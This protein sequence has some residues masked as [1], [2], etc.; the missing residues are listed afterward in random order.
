MKLLTNQRKSIY[1][2][3]Y[4]YKWL[5]ALA[6]AMLLTSTIALSQS[7][8]FSYPENVANNVE[9]IPTIKLLTDSKILESSITDYY[10][11]PDSTEYDFGDPQSI[12]LLPKFVVDSIPDTL[13]KYLSVRGS[14]SL[15]DSNLL[16]F[17]P[18]GELHA[19]LEYVAKVVNLKIV[20]SFNDTF[21]VAEESIT[22]TT[23]PPAHK[24]LSKT[25]FNNGV[26][27][28][29]DTLSV[30]YNRL[31]NSTTTTAGDLLKLYKIDSVKV[32]NDTLTKFTTQLALNSWIDQQD[33]TILRGLP[34]FPFTP[35]AQYLVKVNTNYLTGDMLDYEENDISIK[36]Y[37]MLIMDV[38][39]DDTTLSVPYMSVYPDTGFTYIRYGDSLRIF[40]DREVD[41]LIFLRWECPND[42]E[43]DSLQKNS[44]TISS[45]C[46]N[47][48][49]YYVKAI[50]GEKKDVVLNIS[51]EENLAVSVYSN[52]FGYLGSSG[53]YTIEPDDFVYVVSDTGS[54]SYVFSHWESSEQYINQEE[55]EWN[56][57]AQKGERLQVTSNM[58]ANR[59][60]QVHNF[61]RNIDLSGFDAPE[62]EVKQ[63]GFNFLSYID[64]D[65]ANINIW[66]LE[67]LAFNCGYLEIYIDDIKQ[68]TTEYTTGAQPVNKSIKFVISE[69]A[70]K[71]FTALGFFVDKVVDCSATYTVPPNSTTFS[72]L[73]TSTSSFNTVMVSIKP[74]N[75][76][77][78]DL[79]V[80]ADWEDGPEHEGTG[81]IG[82]DVT[83]IADIL[84]GDEIIDARRIESDGNSM[85]ISDIYCDAQVRLKPLPLYRG[86]HFENWKD[87]DPLNYDYPTPS[88]SDPWEIT[89]DEEKKVKALFSEG[90]RVTHIG[91]YIDDNVESSTH[92]TTITWYDYNL[93]EKSNFLI[94]N[95]EVWD[96]ETNT[97]IG[98]GCK[99][100][101]KFNQQIYKPDFYNE[102]SR[103]IAYDISARVDDHDKE[104]SQRQ[105]YE[106]AQSNSN[107]ENVD[108]PDGNV[109]SLTLENFE[110]PKGQQFRLE[111]K[112]FTNSLSQDEIE[113]EGILEIFETEIP[114]VNIV[115]N[116]FHLGNANCEGFFSFIDEWGEIFIPISTSVLSLNYQ[117]NLY[118]YRSKSNT[119]QWPSTS[120]SYQ[121]KEETTAGSFS[122]FEVFESNQMFRDDFIN[123][124]NESLDEDWRDVPDLRSDA[125]NS[126]EHADNLIINNL[127]EKID[128]ILG[129]ILLNSEPVGDQRWKEVWEIGGAGFAI[130]GIFYAI[131]D[132]TGICEIIA[133][134]I[135]FVTLIICEIFILGMADKI[136]WGITL[137]NWLNHRFGSIKWNNNQHNN[138]GKPGFKTKLKKI[139]QTNSSE[140]Y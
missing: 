11:C 44:F 3:I 70:P 74:T 121:I 84:I 21:Y 2:H 25:F 35:G 78:Y 69:D 82:K 95:I 107:I 52:T 8:T 38:E 112:K 88:S 125:N 103:I 13:W 134:V 9:L 1:I 113:N 138:L 126:R 123:I 137:V 104:Q 37:A 4:I 96:Y 105:T 136:D 133:T 47:L 15:L 76:T 19:G 55:P 128:F 65:D 79:T 63:Y 18:N 98:Y 71:C 117:N 54:N 34:D 81:Q 100:F 91:F 17:T 30:T 12:L 68:T 106:I 67:N 24:V 139:E 111:I 64:L 59:M 14:Y 80:E 39:T 10:Y 129:P 56:M 49:N 87:D 5:P 20:N 29:A 33:S 22:F 66:Q 73:S 90:F 7:S 51:A 97:D 28:C 26:I 32:V 120:T 89:M 48:H 62:P 94:P 77:T 127:N 115:L 85:V 50:Y 72:I 75:L 99:I 132:P 122:E 108:F 41:S 42:E 119:C 58:Q 57:T 45:D 86:F 27:N 46:E 23:V 6:I 109:L 114:G 118:Y 53:T 93:L 140:Y 116:K 110:I 101:F 135:F 92:V 124:F 130:A 131:P 43:L 16:A 83:V 102:F 60:V 36:E 40:A 31:L 61:G